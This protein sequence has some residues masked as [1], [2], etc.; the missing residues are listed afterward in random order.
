MESNSTVNLV[1][2][3]KGVTKLCMRENRNSVFP[4]NMVTPFEHAQFSRAAQH[5]A[6]CIDQ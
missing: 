6:T 5:T 3:G 1:T 4:V 2:L